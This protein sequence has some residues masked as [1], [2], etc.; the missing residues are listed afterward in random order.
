MERIDVEN[1]RKYEK[2]CA[3]EGSGV[4]VR[5]IFVETAF[6]SYGASGRFTFIEF[7]PGNSNDE[8]LELGFLCVLCGENSLFRVFL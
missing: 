2:D 5:P 7:M 4:K 8:A 3:D 1:R 6:A